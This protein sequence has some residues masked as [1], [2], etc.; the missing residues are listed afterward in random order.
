MEVANAEEFFEVYKG[1]LLEY[2]VS[3]CRTVIEE[4]GG[5]MSVKMLCI[6]EGLSWISKK[7]LIVFDFL[8]LFYILN[9]QLHLLRK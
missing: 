6:H 1:V 5:L 8:S 7:G 3:Y 9:N 4:I 2:S